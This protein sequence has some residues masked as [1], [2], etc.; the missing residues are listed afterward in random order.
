MQRGLEEDK[1]DKLN[2]KTIQHINSWPEKQSSLAVSS[3][4]TVSPNAHTYSLV[5]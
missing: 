5:T 4:C 1:H 3:K 2:V